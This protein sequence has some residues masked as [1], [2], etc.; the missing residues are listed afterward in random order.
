[1]KILVAAVLIATS[2]T[3]V[4]GEVRD[5]R[6]PIRPVVG[7]K[8]WSYIHPAGIAR[9]TTH[10]QPVPQQ[11]PTFQVPKGKFGIVL[12]DGTKMI[13]VPAKSWSA[14][15]QTQFGMVTI[16]R[17]QIASIEVVNGLAR[18]HL[19]NGDRVSGQLTSAVLKFETSY[20]ELTVNAG[21]LVRMGTGALRIGTTSPVAGGARPVRSSTPPRPRS[22]AIPDRLIKE[23]LPGDW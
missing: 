3:V 23:A 15:L 22:T 2:A 7:L 19:T 4:F 18:I 21:E 6:R 8:K 11:V 16:P 9:P 14:T 1:M 13:G 12:K 10:R 20:G 17:D 5:I